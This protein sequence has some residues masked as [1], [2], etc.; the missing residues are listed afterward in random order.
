MTRRA[1]AGPSANNPGCGAPVE[2][3]LSSPT[4]ASTAL[5]IVLSAPSPPPPATTLV[6]DSFSDIEA[7]HRAN[8]AS[9][10]YAN[11]LGKRERVTQLRQAPISSMQK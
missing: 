8:V 4:R 5:L 7:A 6:G 1:I 11:K 2:L 10:G 9:T 3:A